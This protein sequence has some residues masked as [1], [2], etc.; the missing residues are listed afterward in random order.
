MD[1]SM[2]ERAVEATRPVVHGTRPDQLGSTTPCPRWDVRKLLNHLIGGAALIAAADAGETVDYSN[3]PDF[4][5]E[6]HAGEF[7]R[8]T[9]AAIE[10]FRAP[11]AMERTFE[12]PWGQTPGNAALGLLLSDM[13]VHGW[14][15]AR[16]TGQ[17]FRVDDDIAEAIYGMTTSMMEPR[18]GFPRGDNFAPPV[19]VADDAPA[20][21][22]MLAYLG[23]D[24]K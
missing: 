6:D 1:A 20:K 14:D 9:K 24:P 17:E 8:N 3:P 7:D 15:L 19:D 2:Y 23:R 18:G 10:I 11:G 13:V 16:A 12:L 22:R 5:S 21:D 4:T